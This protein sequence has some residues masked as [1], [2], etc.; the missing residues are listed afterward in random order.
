MAQAAEAGQ[1]LGWK[2]AAVRTVQRKS[3]KDRM[4]LMTCC[5]TEDVSRWCFVTTLLPSTSNIAREI[6]C[7]PFKPQ[8]ECLGVDM[9]T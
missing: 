5:D 3:G 4:L 1:R 8:L 7:E 2:S 9:H 6:Q